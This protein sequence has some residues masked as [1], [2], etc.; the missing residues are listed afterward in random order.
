MTFI[1]Y[2]YNQRVAQVSAYSDEGDLLGR[3]AACIDPKCACTGNGQHI[4]DAIPWTEYANYV[5]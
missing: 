1:V 4:G 5:A 2:P 3:F